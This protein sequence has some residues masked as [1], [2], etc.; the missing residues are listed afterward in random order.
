MFFYIYKITC[1]CDIW[2]HKFPYGYS[3]VAQ[4][5]G[6]L[7]T[8]PRAHLPTYF[9]HGEW[10]WQQ[11]IAQAWCPLAKCTRFFVIFIPS[12]SPTPPVQHISDMLRQSTTFQ[13][14]NIPAYSNKPTEFHHSNDR[15]QTQLHLSNIYPKCSDGHPHSNI[16]RFPPIP[17]S[18]QNSNI[19]MTGPIE[20][21][22]PPTMITNHLSSLTT[23]STSGT[24]A[25]VAKRP[26]FFRST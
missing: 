3:N 10:S 22:P 6:A 25:N 26:L 16:P 20:Q 12:P 1:I 8:A 11:R 24:S 19:P 9:K 21:H 7:M 14:S 17:T 5:Q 2:L 18:P 13:H 15:P 23:T 4:E